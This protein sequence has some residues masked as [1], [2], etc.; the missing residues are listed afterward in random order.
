[1]RVARW[2]LL[3]IGS[4]VL[5][6]ALALGIWALLPAATPALEGPDPIAALEHVVLGGAEQ[7]L[8]VR[9][10]DRSKPALLYVH[11]G[12]GFAQMAFARHYSEE[13]ERHFVVV[14]WDQRGAGAS[15]DG[16]DFGALTRERMVADLVELSE[17]LRERFGRV[18][19]L[20]HS[21]GSVIGALAVQ[22]R[23][24]LFTA[25]VGLGQVVDGRRN[26]ELSYRFVVDE[27]RRRGDAEALAELERIAPPYPTLNELNV[28]RTVLMRY[29]GSIYVRERAR[30]ALP[31]ALFAREYTLATRLSYFD[32]MRRS[33]DTL[34]LALDDFDAIAQIPRLDVPVFFLTGRRDWNTP[35]VLVEEWAAQLEAPHVEIVWLDEV[36][37][38]APIEAPEAFQ[39]TLIE[40][41][42]P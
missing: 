13:L 9:G 19:L 24:E 15:C 31:M 8:L 29:G 39:R 20:G 5:A 3:G 34:W 36:G 38:M 33:L 4:L 21:W 14:H 1:M 40:K 32:C 23:P 7:Q 35:G 30:E 16:T 25:Y 42:K 26:E 27:A 10:R 12:P 22:Q 37:H 2:L 6:V 17:K 28:Q 41:L 11:G 18:Y